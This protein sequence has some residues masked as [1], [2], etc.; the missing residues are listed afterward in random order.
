MPIRLKEIKQA[1]ITIHAFIDP[2]PLVPSRSLS[3]RAGVPV[4]LKLEN[5]QKTGSFKVRGAFNRVAQLTTAERRSGVVAASAGNHAQ[6]V[7]LAA[8]T[9]NIA[10][11]IVMPE[12]ASIAKQE[13]SRSYGARVI[14]HG[15]DFDAA[16]EKAKEI[17]EGE[18][19]VL[20][21]AFD[22]EAVIAGQGTLA[23]EILKDRPDI[24]TLLVPVGG[25]GI[26]SG[27]AIAAKSLNP[28]I[29]VIGVTAPARPTLAD[30]IAVKF[31]GRITRPLLERY[32]DRMINVAEDEIA[33]AILLLIEHKRIIAE[34]AGA[35]ALAA[36]LNHGR[37]LRGPVC[38]MITGGNIDVTLIERIIDRGLVRTGRLLRFAV[39]LPDR[40]GA[41]AK[42]S[43]AVSELGAKILHI[44]HDRLS[45]GLPITQSRV[46][47]SLETR[48]REHSRRVLAHLKRNGYTLL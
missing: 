20:I 24:R 8:R 37:R 10:A 44:V 45:S 5:L 9:H 21:H 31:P 36:L 35:V 25:G 43:T 48:G 32:L 34:G 16:M 23:L 2:T 28:K 33:E 22:D 47:L 7:A 26:A 30:G 19:R 27:I 17:E 18:E 6:G 12:G 46:D 4:F 41:L 38:L 11:T 42:L 13:A 3:L 29:Q 40:P 39:S 14:I 1:Y 15:K